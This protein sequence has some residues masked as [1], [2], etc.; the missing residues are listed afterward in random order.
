MNFRNL[1]CFVTVLEKG[2]F[3]RA[4][5]KLN[6]PQSSVSR[7][8]IALEEELGTKL[9]HR[10]AKSVQATDSG[11]VLYSKAKDI[12]SMMEDTKCRFTMGDSTRLRLGMTSSV[13]SSL[14][15]KR[16]HIF[17]KRYP[18]VEFEVMEGNTYDL[19]EKIRRGIIE[20]AVV[21][22]PFSTEGLVC[23]FLPPE[24]FAAVGPEETI[25]DL[26]DPAGAEDLS[27]IPLI[28]YRRYESIISSTLQRC[29]ATPKCFCKSDDARTCLHWARAGLGVA[30]V[31]MSAAVGGDLPYKV[32]EEESFKSSIAAVYRRDAEVSEA[33]KYLTSLFSKNE[34]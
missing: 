25:G 26:P 11:V 5:K 4:A 29:G 17:C 14:L 21:R 33:A 23:S 12:L 13:A 16:I 2:S 32:L 6:M 10:G 27:D 30:I 24:P 28:Y 18:N 22:T 34:H 9:L 15:G 7:Y 31:P 3:T 8:I 20:V 1:Q 19:L